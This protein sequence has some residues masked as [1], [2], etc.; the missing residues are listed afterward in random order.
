M[1][2]GILFLVAVLVKYIETFTYCTVAH[3]AL[4]A[5]YLKALLIYVRHIARWIITS[6][7]NIFVLHNIGQMVL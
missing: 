1:L 6:L 3:V 7:P 4:L 2:P 5:V